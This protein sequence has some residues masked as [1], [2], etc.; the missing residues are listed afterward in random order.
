MKTFLKLCAICVI[1][2]CFPGS[3]FAQ[4]GTT[5]TGTTK[6]ADEKTPVQAGLKVLKRIGSPTTGTDVYGTIEVRACEVDSQGRC[7]KDREA[8]CGTNQYLGKSLG[9]VKG[10]GTWMAPDE[11]AG[12]KRVPN[13]GCSPSGLASE[14]TITLQPSVAEPTRLP[15]TEIILMRVVPDVASIDFSQLTVPVAATPAAGKQDQSGG[16]I[17]DYEKW[18]RYA[19]ASVPNAASGAD[20]VFIDVADLN[21]KAKD[22][23]GAVRNLGSAGGGSGDI[24]DVG[25]CATAACFQAVAI[26]QI[27]AGPASG[28]GKSVV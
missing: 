12:I 28:G 3:A 21:L 23:A 7:V 15:K 9:Y 4:T 18:T 16:S 10:D 20:N 26:N 25:N 22:S 8:Q 24:T 17:F 5:V 14:F 2:G 19:A 11:T 1:C 27:F 6:T 13:A